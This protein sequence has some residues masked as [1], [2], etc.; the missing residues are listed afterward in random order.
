MRFSSL[1]SKFLALLVLNFVFSSLKCEIYTSTWELFKLGES[2][3]K[4]TQDLIRFIKSNEDWDEV[5][6]KYQCLIIQSYYELIFINIEI[7]F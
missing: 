2:A 1:N 5:I 7:Y 4:V 6:E 3:Q